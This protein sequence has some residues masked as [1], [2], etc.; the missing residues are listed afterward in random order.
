INEY[1]LG[2]TLESNPTKITIKKDVLTVKPERLGGSI[3]KNISLVTNL[4]VEFTLLYNNELL[5]RVNELTN[6]DMNT[7]FVVLENVNLKIKSDEV[8]EIYECTLKIDLN[9][10]F[11]KADSSQIKISAT[12]IKTDNGYYK[13]GGTY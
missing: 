12:A 4:E 11:K 9:L 13:I 5:E 3:A 2:V 10:N 6:F 8:I 1:E 7:D